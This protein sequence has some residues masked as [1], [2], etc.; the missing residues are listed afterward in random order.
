MSLPSLLIFTADEPSHSLPSHF[1]PQ[2]LPPRTFATHLITSLTDA[3]TLLASTPLTLL[4]LECNGSDAA[5]RKSTK[6]LLR[7]VRYATGAMGKRCLV[8]LW[9]LRASID[10]REQWYWTSQGVNIIC[11]DRANLYKTLDCTAYL[12]ANPS[13]NVQR[14]MYHPTPNLIRVFLALRFY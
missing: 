7:R 5:A 10:P 11:A 9:S 6:D 14:H 1:L 12:C 2:L 8:L 13:T 3:Y 4:I